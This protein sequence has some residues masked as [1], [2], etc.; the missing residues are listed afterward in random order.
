M[1]KIVALYG[2]LAALCFVQAPLSF[3]GDNGWKGCVK[4]EKVVDKLKLS[5]EQK[6][7]LDSIKADTKAKLKPLHEK[8]KTV[9]DQINDS[10]AKGIPD[11]LKQHGFVS[12]EKDII[13]DIL[14]VR[15]QERVEIYKI[16]TDSQKEKL[17]KLIADWKK[18]DKN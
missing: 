2:L 4:F 10:F 13:G 11:D 18:R 6:S 8:M 9:R 14:A 5:S 1:K 7:K 3:A 12:Q 16:L 15:L 17:T